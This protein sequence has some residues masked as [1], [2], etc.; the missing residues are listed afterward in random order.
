MINAVTYD[1]RTYTRTGRAYSHAVITTSK[2]SK[3]PLVEWAS[4]LDLAEK[5]RQSHISR[6]ERVAND[7]VLGGVYSTDYYRQFVDSVVVAVEHPATA[8][9]SDKPAGRSANRAADV[10]DVEDA[11][12]E[13]VVVVE[14]DADA[15]KRARWAANKRASRARLAAKRTKRTKQTAA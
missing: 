2:D 15:A 4:T 7:G 10:D 14:D 3:A 1:G 6:A 5:N 13:P 8:P 12:V 9:A 11:P